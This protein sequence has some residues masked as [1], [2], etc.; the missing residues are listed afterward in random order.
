L[1]G[2]LV[3]IGSGEL[4]VC[5]KANYTT[6]VKVSTQYPPNGGGAYENDPRY[7]GAVTTYDGKRVVCWRPADHDGD[8]QG[9]VVEDEMT[10]S[11]IA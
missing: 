3:S 8:H 1:G 9:E 10:C 5:S 4:H 6:A 2:H 11:W 7:C